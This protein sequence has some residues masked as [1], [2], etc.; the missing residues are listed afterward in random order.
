[1]RD[2][3]KKLEK[4]DSDA[5]LGIFDGKVFGYLYKLKGSCG[6]AAL[7]LFWWEIDGVGRLC[8]ECMAVWSPVSKIVNWDKSGYG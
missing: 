7:H 5:E 1:M 6:A 4:V 8:S 3:W 2:F